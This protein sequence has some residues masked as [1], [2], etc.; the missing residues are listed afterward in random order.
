[1][2]ITAKELRQLKDTPNS[3]YDKIKVE[4]LFHSNKLEGSTFTRENLEKYLKEQIIEGSHEVDDVFE[5]INST[6]L[7]D[8][9]VETLNKPLDESLMMD[10]NQILMKNT[11]NQEWGF[12]GKWKT[13]PNHILGA[14]E[15]LALAQPHEV[16]SK[17]EAL[18]KDWEQSAK[19]FDD[20][21][22]FHV[23]FELIHPFQDGNGRIGRYIILKQC[24]E[25]GLDVIA[26]DEKYNELYK[27][28]LFKAQTKN[29]DSQLREVFHLSQ[30]M[31]DE[32]LKFLE[33]TLACIRSK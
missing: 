15:Q 2:I 12:S 13:I 19:S 30:K 5:T 33:N 8:F 14:S 27:Q 4:F 18:L 22:K 11:R 6:K 31:L 3:G 23:E 21:L 10:F 9:V 17:I 25:N 29:D 28:G 1:M 32:K 16:P 24:V 7:F 20:V 26:I